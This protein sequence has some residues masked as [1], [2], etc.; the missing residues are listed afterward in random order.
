MKFQLIKLLAIFTYS[1]ET[2]HEVH[3]NKTQI[4]VLYLGF[5]DSLF[6]ILH[7]LTHCSC[8]FQQKHENRSLLGAFAHAIATIIKRSSNAN[9]SRTA[10][11][12]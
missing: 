1:N 7:F 8:G 10:P 3:E 5:T 2:F 4:N 6:A 9:C 12:C 11:I